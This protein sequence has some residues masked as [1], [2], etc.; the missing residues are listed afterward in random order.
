MMTAFGTNKKYIVPCYFGVLKLQIVFTIRYT[1]LK[2]Q[3]FL[4]VEI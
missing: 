1:S 4:D 2:E 3:P